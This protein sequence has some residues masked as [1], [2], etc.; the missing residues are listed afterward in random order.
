MLN[1]Y[2]TFLLGFM[3]AVFT[4]FVLPLGFLEGRAGAK[5][6]TVCSLLHHPEFYLAVL[7]MFLAIFSIRYKKAVYGTLLVSILIILHGLTLNP[8]GFY[9]AEKKA[10]YVFAQKIA[11]TSHTGI[12]P[13]I[14][15]TGVLLFM[16][17]VLTFYWSKK[18]GS[19]GLGIFYIAKQYLLG[20]FFRLICFL[21]IFSIVSATV[22]SSFFLTTSLTDIAKST[23]S[24]IEGDLVVVPENKLDKAKDLFIN[25][26][27]VVFH[28]NKGIQA[29]LKTLKAVEKTVS[30]LFI[31]PFSYA[32]ESTIEN[33][34]IIVYE[35]DTDFIVKP[36]IEYG[37]EK[38][39]PVFSVITGALVKYYPG[40]EVKLFGQKFKVSSTL[41]RTGLGYFDKSIFIT[42]DALKFILEN[43]KNKPDKGQRKRKPVPLALDFAHIMG[44]T[45]ALE[46]GENIPIDEIDP[47]RRSAIFIKAHNGKD[48]NVFSKTIEKTFP[49]LSVIKIHSLSS[50]VKESISQITDMF[51]LPSLI[52]VVMA[53]LLT[54]LV[55]GMIVNERARQFGIL[56][57]LGAECSYIKWLVIIEN[58]IVSMLGAVLGVVLSIGFLFIFKDHVSNSLQVHYVWPNLG[59]LS[60]MIVLS[61]LSSVFVGIFASAVPAIKAGRLEPY[62]AIKGRP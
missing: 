56:R 47:N 45:S 55:L 1:A 41:K 54:V 29:Q 62:L 37:L 6:Q 20:S 5:V 3:L 59:R 49:D 25:G 11:L 36:W 43:A 60:L 31:N 28:I 13:F 30:H 4:H 26:K 24:Q 22:F 12:R 14:I 17:S 7:I 46:T 39:V 42:L 15:V 19:K 52:V 18:Y 40:Q 57:A 35:A 2:I 33:V 16:L 51:F 44:D 50:G 48:I 21:L 34:S 8:L 27:P 23:F 9:L 38:K 10:L 61:I 58:T 32:I 53:F